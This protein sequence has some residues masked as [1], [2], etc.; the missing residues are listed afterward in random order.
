MRFIRIEVDDTTGDAYRLASP[1]EQDRIQRIV[2]YSVRL[3]QDDSAF[4]DASERL[5]RTVDA[6][7]KKAE[8]RGATEQIIDNLLNDE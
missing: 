1:E 5:E 6:I 2:R 3:L 4:D 8:A 7:G